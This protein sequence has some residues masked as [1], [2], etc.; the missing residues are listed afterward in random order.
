MAIASCLTTNVTWA[1]T[2]PTHSR[3]EEEVV[4]LQ[5]L[6]VEGWIFFKY[7]L[8]QEALVSHQSA[9]VKEEFRQ[10]SRH[11]LDNVP[12]P[13]QQGVTNMVQTTSSSS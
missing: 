1:L 5:R 2:P 13:W 9:L 12:E 7:S 6:L 10:H 11:L 3:W 8:T 4:R